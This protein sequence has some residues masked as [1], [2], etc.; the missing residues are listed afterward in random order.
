VFAFYDENDYSH[1]RSFYIIVH[2]FF[3]YVRLS[4]LFHDNSL[5]YMMEVYC[6]NQNIYNIYVSLYL[7]CI[8]SMIINVLH[9]IHLFIYLCIYVY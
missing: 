1:Y 9:F 6:Y 7:D 3:L 8:R 5:V 2:F 4:V